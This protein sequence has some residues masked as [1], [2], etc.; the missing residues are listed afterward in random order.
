MKP[1]GLINFL[2]W[3]LFTYMWLGSNL[4]FFCAIADLIHDHNEYIRQKATEKY[5]EN[6]D[7][8]GDENEDE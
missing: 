1:D 7:E 5:I 8:S 2:G 4:M 3:S 6:E